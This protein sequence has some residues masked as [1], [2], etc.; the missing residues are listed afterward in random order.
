MPS[1]TN[2][3]RLENE[4]RPSKRAGVKRGC[5]E[6]HGKE[7][8]KGKGGKREEANGTDDLSSFK[9]M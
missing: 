7:S 9:E 3:T 5:R 1:A 4:D 6:V 8:G 2:V